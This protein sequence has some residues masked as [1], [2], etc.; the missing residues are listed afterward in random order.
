[1]DSKTKK[2]LEYFRRICFI[3]RPSGHE[4]E[5]SAYLR[6]WAE[7]QGYTS[8]T[9]EVGNLIVD[10][11]ARIGYE[12]K[13]LIILQAHMDMVCIGEDGYE[14]NKETDPIIIV[15]EGEF[16]TAKGTSLG[17]DD[18]IG[19]AIAQYLADESQERGRLRLIF[20]VDEEETTIGAVGL[21]A[22]HLDAPYLINLDSEVSDKVMV[23]SAGCMELYGSGELKVS[24]PRFDIGFLLKLGGLMGGHSGDDIDKGRLSA[25]TAAGNLMRRLDE[26]QV[27]WELSSLS[28]GVAANAIP[29][30]AVIKGNADDYEMLSLLI[31][32]IS[33]EMKA[34]YPEEKELLLS[35]EKTNKSQEIIQKENFIGFLSQIPKGVI[36]MWDNKEVEP[37]GDQTV[38]TSSNIGIINVDCKHTDFNI[39]V[40][41]E[42]EEDILQTV[43]ETEEVAVLHGMRCTRS[44]LTPSWPADMNSLLLK[45]LQEAYEEVTGEYLQPIA[46]H[47][48]LECAEFRA[49]NKDI[50]MVSISPDVYDVHSTGE[51]LYIPSVGKTIRVLEN[52]I[53][54]I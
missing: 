20:T 23:S 41:A 14:Y 8:Q 24:E 1:M 21:S 9:D 32:Q 12:E 44:S 51:R 50:E 43:K 31:E 39:L 19:I 29:T 3:P 54:N 13:P 40:R 27:N 33:K 11:D 17:G 30:R 4:G 38:K 16:L 22:K 49:K 18:G 28:G 52:L 35:V 45:K 42:K 48:V 37:L 36:S 34:E 10:C 6:S 46:V 2:A 53:K 7:K 26:E 15:E 5:I 47:A 25:I